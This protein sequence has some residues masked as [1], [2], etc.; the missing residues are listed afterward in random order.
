M[1]AEH[2]ERDVPGPLP[3]LGK[4]E[5]AEFALPARTRIFLDLQESDVSLGFSRNCRVIAGWFVE[6]GHTY[7]LEFTTDGHGCG[8][9]ATDSAA[10]K[11]VS[12]ITVDD[13]EEL[14]PQER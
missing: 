9:G 2:R 12:L 4:G 3:R 14:V 1:D 13:C 7:E 11:G 6:P 10:A 5:V 8:V